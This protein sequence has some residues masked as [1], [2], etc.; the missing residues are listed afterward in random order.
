MIDVSQLVVSIDAHRQG[1]AVLIRP[2]LHNPMPLVLHYRLTVRQS[3]AA[4]T[5]SIDQSGDLQSGTASSVISLS[6]P[7]GASCRAY[8]QVF[9]NDRLVREV[10]SDCSCQSG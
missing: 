10:D 9:D 5:S 8:L 7:A 3:S 2:M 6:L 1:Q 4:G